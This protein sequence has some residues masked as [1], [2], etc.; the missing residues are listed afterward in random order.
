MTDPDDKD[1]FGKEHTELSLLP[2]SVDFD[3]MTTAT[4][5]VILRRLKNVTFPSN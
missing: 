1:V 2:R 3:T 4:A 5:R